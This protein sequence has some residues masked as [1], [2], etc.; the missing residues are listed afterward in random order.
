MKDVKAAILMI[1]RFILIIIAVTFLGGLYRLFT[2]PM[3][4]LR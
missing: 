3:E 2:N 4:L 1:V